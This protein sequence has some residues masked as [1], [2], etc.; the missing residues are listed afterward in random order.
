MK[1]LQRLGIIFTAA[2]LLF[3]SCKTEVNN[4]LA[5]HIPKNAFLVTTFNAKQ[6]VEKGELNKFKEFNLYK[7]FR[8]ELAKNNEKYGN[9]L[10]EFM[11]NT[12][13]SGLNLDMI[14][15][16]TIKDTSDSGN[17]N[18]VF[19]FKMDNMSTFESKLKELTQG[20]GK[21]PE[22]K[23]AYKQMNL[24]YDTDLVWNK[25]CLYIVVGNYTWDEEDDVTDYS[26]LF[27]ENK[28]S[29]MDNADFAELA[30]QNN[31][32]SL[33]MSYD[34]LLTASGLSDLV[35]N[36][37]PFDISA[38]NLN[39][40]LNFN[41]G[42]VKLTSSVS[43]KSKIEEVLKEY[44]IIKKD[45]DADLLKYLPEK[46]YSVMKLSFNVQEVVKLIQKQFDKIYADTT[47]EYDQ[48][49]VSYR[50]GPLFA[51]SEVMKSDAFT[52][53]SNGLGGDFII[54]VYDFQKGLMS[55]PLASLIFNVKNK[56]TFDVIVGLLPSELLKKQEKYY[57]IMAGPLPVGY[58]AFKD[59][60][61]FATTDETAVTA[62][63]DKGI[64]KNI[65]HSEIA[66][67]LKNDIFYWNLNLDLNSY[68]EHINML[69]R[70]TMGRN[71]NILTSFLNIYKS[72]EYKVTNDNNVEF[73]VK[74]QSNNN[75]S[76]KTIL[77]NLDEN[78][79]SIL[80]L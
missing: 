70:T 1:I 11:S 48:Y 28:T 22:S 80:G 9:M 78:I 13:T 63:L 27:A 74:M 65:A 68:P 2:I 45:F 17:I 55:M 51:L 42:D 46:S 15:L 77:K 59:N 75:N 50:Y 23:S 49:D 76:L 66:S 35:K 38:L 44:P 6:M 20:E 25:E 73:V 79:P 61:V 33:W 57:T 8:D 60:K 16:Y 36:Q 4:D 26:Y 34:Q 69:L 43:P 29:I 30:K 64:E 62:F 10:D 40:A 14:Y 56:E 52:T 31:D 67:D 21:E 18:A 39:S 24:N 3:A 53:I 19:L 72:V 37:I 58:V 7:I 41:N 47:H 71:Y 54:S 32:I 5:L 12:R